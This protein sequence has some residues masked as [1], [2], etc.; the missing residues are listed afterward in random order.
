MVLLVFGNNHPVKYAYLD[1]NLLGS[2]GLTTNV[3]MR[4]N[5]AEWLNQ[6]GL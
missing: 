2:N 5:H 4:S 1:N 6:L 3:K